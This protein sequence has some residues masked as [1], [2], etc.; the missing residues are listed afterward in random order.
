MHRPVALAAVLMLPLGLPAA[1]EVTAEEVWTSLSTVLEAMTAGGDATFDIGSQTIRDGRVT[2]SGLTLRDTGPDETASLTIDR[3]DFIETGDGAVSVSVSEE[4]SLVIV[5]GDGQPVLLAATLLAEGVTLLVSGD[6]EAMAYDLTAQRIGAVVE[7]GVYDTATVEAMEVL[8]SGTTGQF[9]MSTEG[10]LDI[11]YALRVEEVSGSLKAQEFANF[12][13]MTFNLGGLSTSLDAQLPIE[14]MTDPESLEGQEMPALAIEGGYTIAS[15]AVSVAFSEDSFGTSTTGNGAL[16][17]ADINIAA[18]ADTTT[19]FSLDYTISTGALSGEFDFEEAAGDRLD[20]GAVIDGVSLAIVLQIPVEAMMA[21]GEIDPA[22]A[23]DMTMRLVSEAGGGSLT[24]DGDIEGQSGTLEMSSSG[25]ATGFSFDGGDLVMDAVSNAPRLT[26]TGFEVPIPVEVSLAEVG[27][28]FA[29]PL[30]RSDEMKD[31]AL[32]VTVRDL[33]IGDG[34]WQLVDPAAFLPRDPL[35]VDIGFSGMGRALFDF[36]DP[37]QQAALD[38]SDMPVEIESLSLD[39]LEINGGGARITG[40]GAFTFDMSD[41]ATS[42]GL[43]RPEGSLELD[44]VGV[45]GLIDTLV[46]MGLMADSDA[47]GARLGLSMITRSVGDDV[48]RSDIGV[49]G[50]GHLFVNGQ[51][52]R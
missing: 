24:M 44:A 49:T 36:Y 10:T 15:G 20:L 27:Y 43:P 38:A 9:E 12:V 26:L 2:V 48:L 42:D 25:G 52:L 22:F 35:T 21:E 29:F 46:A 1:A 51:R 31:M 16:T 40:T 5:G 37:A 17:V 30:G 13:D 41:L 33:V 6:P 14:L 39:R 28:S 50:E 4:N 7:P 32:G 23:R 34:L 47:A 18:K 11:R 3:L 8:A 45:N 19:D